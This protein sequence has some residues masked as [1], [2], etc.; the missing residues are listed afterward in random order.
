MS[1]RVSP[2]EKIK[3]QIGAR[4]G[5]LVEQGSSVPEVIEGLARLG[6]QLLIQ[7][8]LEAEMDEYLGRDRYQRVAKMPEARPGKRNGY[9]PTTVK[10]TAGPVELQRP[11]LRGTTEAFASRLLGAGV[12]KSNAFESL[13]IA[14]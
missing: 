13:V 6:A 7:A 8:A 3:D 4:V 9:Q 2:A 5:E 1:V 11:K 10:T 12:S 14:G